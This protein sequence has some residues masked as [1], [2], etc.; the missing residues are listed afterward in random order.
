MGDLFHP[1]PMFHEFTEHTAF[2]GAF[3][4][5]GSFGAF[6]LFFLPGEGTPTLVHLSFHI[7]HWNP[8]SQNCKCSL[9]MDTHVFM[10]ECG[11]GNPVTRLPS[12]MME[13]KVIG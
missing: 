5:R 13:S 6:S 1:Q 2:T 9:E 11:L 8:S 3:V 4:G 10:C 7:D 12:E